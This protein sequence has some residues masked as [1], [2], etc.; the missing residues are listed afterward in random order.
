MQALHQKLLSASLFLAT[1][2]LASAHGTGDTTSSLYH[3]LTNPDHV[4]LF[5]LVA[6]AGGI[7]LTRNKRRA[8][9]QKQD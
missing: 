6:L 7:Y 5:G 3:Y 4:A 8:L 1:I 9:S 2:P